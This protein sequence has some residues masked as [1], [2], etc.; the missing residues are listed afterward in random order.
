MG[1]D[2]MAAELLPARITDQMLGRIRSEYL[3]MPGLCLTLK[4]AQRLGGL[5]EETCR[6]VMQF[7][8][9]TKVLRRVVVE[10]CNLPPGSAITFRR[11]QLVAVQL[12]RRAAA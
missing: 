11:L 10:A 2:I 5:D 9:D 1:E 7:L 12:D 6:E 4:Q 8:V 3:E